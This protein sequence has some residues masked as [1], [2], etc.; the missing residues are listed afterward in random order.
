MYGKAPDEAGAWVSC[1]QAVITLDMIYLYV[2]AGIGWVC[3][4]RYDVI[5]AVDELAN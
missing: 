2:F 3:S 1:D 5:P 4:M